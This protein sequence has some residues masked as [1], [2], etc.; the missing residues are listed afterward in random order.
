METE[1][2]QLFSIV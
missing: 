2:A 1:N